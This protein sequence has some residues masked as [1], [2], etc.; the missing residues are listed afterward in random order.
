VIAVKA[1]V[2]RDVPVVDIDPQHRCVF[3]ALQGFVTGASWRGLGAGQPTAL[4][5]RLR[6]LRPPDVE[7]R[8]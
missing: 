1:A 3:N 7:R 4:P 2:E 8:H 5:P 6:T